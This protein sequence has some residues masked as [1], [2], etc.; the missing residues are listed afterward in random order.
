MSLGYVKEFSYR[1]EA[2]SDRMSEIFDSAQVLEEKS[3]HLVAFTGAGIST[4]G[5]PDFRGLDGVRSLQSKGEAVPEA[6]QP[7]HCAMLGIT[8]M[9]LAELE[10]AGILKCVISQNIDSLHLRSGIPREK[11][12]ELHGNSFREKC[13]SCEEEYLRDFEIETIGMKLTPRRCTAANCNE[14]LRDSVVDW[15]GALSPKEM[16]LAE[17]HC[18]KA[19]VVLCLGTSL[20]T[21]PAANFPLLCLLGGGKIVIINLQ[22]TPKDKGAS[23]II[24]GNVDKVMSG[25]IHGLDLRIPP[26]VQVDLFEISFIHYPKLSYSGNVV[27]YTLRIGNAIGLEAKFSLIKSVEVT[28]LDR[29]NLKNAILNKK[30]FLLKRKISKEEPFTFVVKLN[31]CD[32][33]GIHSTTAEFPVNFQKQI[34]N[35]SCDKDAVVRELTNAAIESGCCG[36]TSLVK[37]ESLRTKRKEIAVFAVAT[38]IVCYE[39]LLDNYIIPENIPEEN[40]DNNNIPEKNNDNIASKLMPLKKRKRHSLSSELVPPKKR[41]HDYEYDL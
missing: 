25:I 12:A 19:D 39:S 23:L 31:F 35:V 38:N 34:E 1:E 24:H 2:G 37:R 40:R 33:C 9:A 16:Q 13:S 4:C 6:A 28:F 11:L 36:Q 5:I 26:S 15:M 3:K 8:H 22:P 18:L 32:G 21:T 14:R 30:P 29:L 17:K 41:K 7:F 20:R 27:Q 10:K